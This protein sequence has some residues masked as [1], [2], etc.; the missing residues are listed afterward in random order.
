[1]P[2]ETPQHFECCAQRRQ[3]V[4]KLTHPVT[5]LK[6]VICRTLDQIQQNRFFE[7]M[8]KAMELEGGMACE[9]TQLPM[10]PNKTQVV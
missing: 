4:A 5:K 6:G 2:A 3:A 10:L 1:V 7:A 8:L 9:L